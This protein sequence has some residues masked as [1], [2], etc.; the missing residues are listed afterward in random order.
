MP[1]NLPIL[2]NP[3]VQVQMLQNGSLT[4]EWILWFQR[5]YDVIVEQQEQP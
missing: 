3:P 5:V 2:P 4:Q 1:S